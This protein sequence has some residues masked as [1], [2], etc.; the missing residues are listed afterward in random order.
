MVQNIADLDDQKELEDAGESL[1]LDWGKSDIEFA[2][3]GGEEKRRN[4]VTEKEVRTEK[5]P[6]DSK[7]TII[8]RV[9]GRREGSS[10]AAGKLPERFYIST[11]PN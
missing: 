3:K 11:Y 6:E 7:V 4:S 8:E 9:S 10:S 5:T 1:M 2:G